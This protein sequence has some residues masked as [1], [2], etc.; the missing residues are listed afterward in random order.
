VDARADVYALG[1]VLR[2]AGGAAPRPLRSIIERATEPDPARRYQTVTD[3]SS[4]VANF[5]DHQQ[6]RAH[7]ETWPERLVRV[8]ARHRTLAWLILAYLAMRV[9]LFFLVRP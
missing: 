9:L 3:L 5:L 8:L 6:V 7:H 2:K 1:R 4:D